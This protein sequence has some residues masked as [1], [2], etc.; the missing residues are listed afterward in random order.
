[1]AP[2]TYTPTP[3]HKKL[4]PLNTSGKVFLHT[5]KECIPFRKDSHPNCLKT[6]LLTGAVY[7][8]GA[9]ENAPVILSVKAE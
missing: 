2:H 1:M 9:S 8:A 6:L 5:Q 4:C 3:Q 7:P